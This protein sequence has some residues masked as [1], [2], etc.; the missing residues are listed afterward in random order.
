MSASEVSRAAHGGRLIGCWGWRVYHPA[1]FQ[2]S[3]RAAF[4]N[5][6]GGATFLI[7]PRE[8][9]IGGVLEDEIQKK[10]GI[11][12]QHLPSLLEGWTQYC[13]LHQKREF[14]MNTESRKHRR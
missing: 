12:K 7:A 9:I 11:R 10:S 13:A 3:G 4:K 8:S 14:L 1:D 5:Y 2:P 6:E